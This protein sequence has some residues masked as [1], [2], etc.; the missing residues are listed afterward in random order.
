MHGKVLK[1]GTNT[2]ISA[3]IELWGNDEKGT[4]E[5]TYLGQTGSNG[6]GTFD[7]KTDI[8][9]SEIYYLYIEPYDTT[10]GTVLRPSLKD[11]HNVDL[12]NIMLR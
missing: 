6:D 7:L 9:S 3:T 12:G 1:S 2:P 11:G 5:G 8:A 10:Q 4:K